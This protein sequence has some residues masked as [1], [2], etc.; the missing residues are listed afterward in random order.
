MKLFF[1]PD[2]AAVRIK[3][4]GI[5]R[6]SDAVAAIDAGADAIGI[7]LVAGSKRQVTLAQAAA[8]IRKAKHKITTV[9]VVM[10]PTFEKAEALLT[11]PLFDAIQLHGLESPEFCDRLRQFQKP[12]IK[13][14][15]VSAE[16][17]GNHADE[18]PVNAILLD[19][20]AGSR[21][22]GTG[23]RFAWEQKV[24]LLLAKPLIL[25]GGLTP[26]NVEQ[27]ISLLHPY[28]VDVASGVESE[29]GQKNFG[30]LQAF[31]VA[32]RRAA[33][34]AKGQVGLPVRARTV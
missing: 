12:V 31:V 16:W 6:W 22:G 14:I 2:P 27:A 26:D 7:N 9:A 20:S 15:G 13:A 8:W 28:A 25:S 18:Y 5:T 19:S 30:K 17:S 1:Q 33:D 4:C 24:G 34:L 11:C 32:A 23:R 21:L 29:P 10:N 3:I